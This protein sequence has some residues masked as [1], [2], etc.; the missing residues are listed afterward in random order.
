MR[1][2]YGNIIG[3]RLRSDTGAKWAVAGSHQGIFLPNRPAER[4]AVVCEGPTDTAAALSLGLWAVGR[5]SCSAGLSDVPKVFKRLRIRRAV[6]ISDNDIPGLNGAAM[7]GRH[8]GIPYCTLVLPTKD[9]R[10]FVLAGG[11]AQM[12]ENLIND[13]VWENP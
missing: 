3:I 5:A 2:G 7:L 1:D 4:T 9:L 11:T 6:I 8:L 13:T 12:L 10:K